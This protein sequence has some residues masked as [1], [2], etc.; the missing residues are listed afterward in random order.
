MAPGEPTT[1]SLRRV[2]LGLVCVAVVTLGLVPD[3]GADVAGPVR[4]F[5]NHGSVVVRIPHRQEEGLPL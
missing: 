1:F 2:V 3:A 5:G 4:S